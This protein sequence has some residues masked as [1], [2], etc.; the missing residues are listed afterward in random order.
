MYPFSL[1]FSSSEPVT[2][3]IA[4]F[5]SLKASSTTLIPSGAAKRQIAVISAAPRSIRN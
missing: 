5:E 1:S 4:T 2:R 3:V